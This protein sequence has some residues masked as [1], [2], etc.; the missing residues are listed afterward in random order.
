MLRALAARTLRHR[1]RTLVHLVSGMS[2]RDP[3]VVSRLRQAV[4]GSPVVVLD[5]TSMRQ[6][7]D[8]EVPAQ[9]GTSAAALR[10]M[11]A[12]LRDVDAH[13]ISRE[14]RRWWAGPARG[15]TSAAVGLGLGL[16][17]SFGD[18]HPWWRTFALALLGVAAIGGI[19]LL[20]PEVWTQRR[21]LRLARP[22]RGDRTVVS[23]LTNLTPSDWEAVLARAFLLDLVDEWGWRSLLSSRR[24]R[25]PYPVLLLPRDP[26]APGS[27]FIEEY[28]RFARLPAL[29][30]TDRPAKGE[31]VPLREWRTLRTRP[32]QP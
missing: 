32:G 22:F 13:Q 10:L 16:L 11:D 12:N 7:L 29:L 15:V 27:T 18:V 9:L 28:E 3:D 14:P 2:L 8:A 20:T 19:A 30:V 23:W 4:P 26:S 31:P 5:G 21:L 17:Q 24:V 6:L 1:R 25:G